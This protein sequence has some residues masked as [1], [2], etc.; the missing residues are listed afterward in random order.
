MAEVDAPPPVMFLND[1]R[2]TGMEMH[3]PRLALPLLL[4]AWPAG[5]HDW[6]EGLPAPDGDPCCGENACRPVPYR[7]RIACGEPL[8]I[9]T[10]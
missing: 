3:V 7:L 5:A 10:A 2:H 6:H 9:D 8:I 4:L 1:E